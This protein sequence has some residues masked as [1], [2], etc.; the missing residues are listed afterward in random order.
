MNGF[1]ILKWPD[2]KIYEGNYK[3]DNKNGFGTFIWSD[4]R[5]YIG[6]WQDGK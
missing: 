4:G 5:K 6:S 2:G 1:G 3:D